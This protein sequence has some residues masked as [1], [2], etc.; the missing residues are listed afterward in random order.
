MKIKFTGTGD[1]RGIPAVGCRC[2]RC[3][4]TKEKSGKDSR[5]QDS[6]II[7]DGL[8][9][10]LFDTPNSIG[11]ILNEENIYHI[12]AIFLSNKYY[13]HLGGITEFEYWPEKIPVYGNIS[14][15]G[16]FE[17]TARLYEKCEFHILQ[18]K[19]SVRINNIRVMP[20]EVPYKVPTFGLV[21]KKDEKR[22]VY[23]SDKKGSNLDEFQKRLVKKSDVVIFHTPYFDN[24]TDHI[25]VVSV[26]KIA[27]R[28]PSTRFVI[29]HIGHDNLSHDELVE[30]LFPY[31]NIVVA[32]DR[33]EIKV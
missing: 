17:I 32:Y 1:A 6:I 16:N 21:L 12:T 9:T 7:T 8:E 10:I 23:F 5:R 20:F 31:K 18:N 30:R 24:S 19:K 3:M 28:Y 25:G 22:I 13:N 26:I 11:K 2:E 29:T 14:N 27:K 4:T 15:L 33:L